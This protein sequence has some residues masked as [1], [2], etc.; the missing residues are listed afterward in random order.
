MRHTKLIAPV[1]LLAAGLA[2][3]SP[4]AGTAPEENDPAG[5]F[6]PPP[7]DEVYP[8]PID[9]RGLAVLH[10]GDSHVSRGLTEGLSDHLR[11]AGARYESVTWVGSRSRS[12]VASGKLKKLLRERSPGAVIVT[13]GTNAIRHPQPRR[14][15]YWDHALVD[16]IGRRRCFWLGPPSLIADRHGLNPALMESTTPCRYFETRLLD[17]PVPEN[18]KFHLTRAQGL[19]WAAAAWVWMNGGPPPR[20]D[21]A[22]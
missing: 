6:L 1:A 16:L 19:I 22:L 11:L 10:I 18:G 17:F 7:V 8:L 9:W 13:L 5:R 2:T 21:D 14:L 4:V 15:A 20:G 3:A 12:W